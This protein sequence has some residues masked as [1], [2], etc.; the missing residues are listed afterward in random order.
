MKRD[1]NT[2]L[3]STIYEQIRRTRMTDIERQMA[4]N[5]LRQ[6]DAIVDAF[7]WIV[8]K[9]SGGGTCATLKPSLKH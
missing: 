4:L 5:A 1:T 7:T 8:N 6:A 2:A 9:I 3:G